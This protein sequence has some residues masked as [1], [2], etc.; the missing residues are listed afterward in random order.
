[1][2]IRKTTLADLP[3][4]M[5]IYALAR[6]FMAANGNPTQ[7]AERNWPPEDLIRSD[8]AAGDSYVCEHDGRVIAVF[9]YVEGPDIEPTYRVIE[10][11]DW[12][13][14]SPYGVVHRIAT[15][16]SVRGTVAS[17]PMGTTSPCSGSSR[18]SALSAAAPSM[19]SKTRTRA[20]L[21]KSHDQ[22]TPTGT[23]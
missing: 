18:K 8:I 11:G 6:E 13:D 14:D 3:R 5:E 4:V 22:A 12:A 2:K 19:S 16:G 20:T 7:W 21:M 15:D 17:T 10:D 9:Y 23:A 1:M